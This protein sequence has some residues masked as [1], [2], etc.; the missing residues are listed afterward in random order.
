MTIPLNTLTVNNRIAVS[1]GYGRYFIENFGNGV[2]M[3]IDDWW[4]SLA[5]YVITPYFI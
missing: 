4:A 5:S 1:M 3:G 2:A